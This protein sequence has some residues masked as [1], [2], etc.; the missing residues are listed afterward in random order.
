MVYW[1]LKRSAVIGWWEDGAA[2]VCGDENEVLL[3]ARKAL[4]FARS[5]SNNF[6]HVDDSSLKAFGAGSSWNRS[7]VLERTLWVDK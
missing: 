1:S 6:P 4:V 7:T 3:E 5:A 2:S